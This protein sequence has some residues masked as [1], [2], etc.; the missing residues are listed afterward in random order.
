[1]YKPKEIIFLKNDCLVQVLPKKSEYI[2]EGCVFS[3][4]N[5]MGPELF[6]VIYDCVA[7]KRKYLPGYKDC[8]CKDM[9]PRG[10]IFKFI[11]FAK[12]GI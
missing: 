10:Y 1:M 12:G 2:C 6:P 11:G 7:R 9:L 5:P 4:S 3:I 8:D